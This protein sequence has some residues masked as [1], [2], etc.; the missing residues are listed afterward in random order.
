MY[1]NTLG[2]LILIII[3]AIGLGF[4]LITDPIKKELKGI[5]ETLEKLIKEKEE[6][7]EQTQKPDKPE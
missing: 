6:T 3:F 7:N 2:I 4:Y 1:E 5:K